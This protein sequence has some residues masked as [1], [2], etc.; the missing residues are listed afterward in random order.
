[1]GV[2]KQAEFNTRLK[3]EMCA[4]TYDAATDTISLSPERAAAVEQV[5]KHYTD[6]F[7]D[8]SSLDKLREQYAMS[9]V[10]LPD[11]DE[12]KAL[13]AFIF[14]SA[15]SAWSAATDRPGDIDLS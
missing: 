5:M 13:P 8:A 10:L 15:W 14:W 2:G 1:M 4:N 12:L 11:A 7:G 9:S 3:E 6:L